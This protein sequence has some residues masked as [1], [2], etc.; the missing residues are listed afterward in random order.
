MRLSLVLLSQRVVRTSS[1]RGRVTMS[2]DRTRPAVEWK[3]ILHNRAPS[4]VESP[5]LLGDSRFAV[6]R[7]AHH[8]NLGTEAERN[9]MWAKNTRFWQV[10]DEGFQVTLEN[11]DGDAAPSRQ[12]N[13]D[14]RSNALRDEKI[15]ARRFLFR[16]SDEH[17]SVM[18]PEVSERLCAL[19][20]NRLEK[21]GVPRVAFTPAE[22]RGALVECNHEVPLALHYLRCDAES[23]DTPEWDAVAELL[24]KG[25]KHFDCGVVSCDM[26]DGHQASVIELGCESVATMFS[27]AFLDLAKDI[28]RTA[29]AVLQPESAAEG[30]AVS[31]LLTCQMHN[32]DVYVGDALLALSKQLLEVITVRRVAL[33]PNPSDALLG[34]H[35]NN[36]R[37]RHAGQASAVCFA[38]VLLGQQ[39]SNLLEPE[40]RARLQETL[41]HALAQHCLLEPLWFNEEGRML[42]QPFLSPLPE[43]ELM[44]FPKGRPTL[45]DWLEDQSTRSRVLVTRFGVVNAQLGMGCAKTWVS[46][47]AEKYRYSKFS[48]SVD[49][50]MV[51]DVSETGNYSKDLAAPDAKILPDMQAEE[52]WFNEPG[53]KTFTQHSEEDADLPTGFH[54]DDELMNTRAV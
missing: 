14:A 16:Q 50:S 40:W 54:T 24:R 45:F 29:A 33:V 20:S 37:H 34:W 36:P 8:F 53:Q 28:S 46:Y 38:L 35:L 17:F 10:K 21:C 23:R 18:D 15:R 51:G 44:R 47:A 6:T 7:A 19:V 4:G 39:D 13:R 26:I 25:Q 1:R 11:L 12:R 43:H 49:P 52:M 48:E 27:D 30:C 3:D 42:K 9:L 41:P 5:G 32:S 22:V 31:S 2:G